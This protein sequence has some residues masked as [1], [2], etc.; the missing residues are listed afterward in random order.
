[1]LCYSCFA[2]EFIIDNFNNKG[3][4]KWIPAKWGNRKGASYSVKQDVMF[5]NFGTADKKT[6]KGFSFYA[7]LE[8][9]CDL[10]TYKYFCFKAR[11]GTD[12]ACSVRIY[13]KKEEPPGKNSSYYSIIRLTSEWKTYY[14]QLKTGKRSTVSKGLFI[15]VYSKIDVG[16]SRRLES[17]GKLKVLTFYSKDAQLVE[18]DD[19]VLKNDINRNSGEAEAI[20]E[21]IKKHKKYPP[22]KFRKVIG[23]NGS[24]LVENGKSSFVI[25]VDKNSGETGKFAA[26]QLAEYIKKSTGAELKIVE[27]CLPEQK[28][29]R[30]LIA[31]TVKHKEGFSTEALNPGTIVICGYD[32]RGLLYG[33]Y[34]FLEKALGIRWFAPFDYAEVI[35]TKTNVKLPLWKDESFPQ[36]TY[37][38]FHYCS[39]G[40]GVPDPMKH[41]YQVADWCV[42]NRYNVELERLVGKWDKPAVKKARMAKIKQFYVKRGG[43]IALPTMWG[44]NYHYW[45]SPKEYFKKHPEYFCFDSSTK[46]WR[47]ERAQLCATNP[48]LVKAIVKRAVEY[49]KEHPEREYFPLFQEDGS[50]LWC[51]CPKCRALYKGTDING[52]KTEHNINLMNL[53]AAKLAKVV[54]GK[55]VATYAYQVTSSPPVNVK[56]RDDIFVTYCL[57]GFSEPEKIPW[58]GYQGGE[59]A[60]WNKLCRGNLI[61]YTYHYLDFNYTAITPAALTRTFRYFNLMKIKGSCQES[62]ENWY[63]VSAY[64]YYLGA[65]LAWDPW[66][67]EKACRKDYYEKLYGKASSFIEE[68]H[69]VLK[70]CLSNRKYWLE[71]GN[72][73]FPYVPSDKLNTMQTCLNKAEIAAKGSARVNKAVEAQTRGFLYVKTFSEAVVAGAEF[74]KNPDTAKYQKAVKYLEQLN[75]VVKDLGRDRLVTI[76][77]LRTTRGMRRNLR[78]N[79]LRSNAFK[80]LV[81]EF[82][83]LKTLNPWKFKTD[84]Q[85]KGDR[86]KWFT[87]DFDDTKWKSIKSG[88]FWEKQG[89]PTYNGTGWYR[90]KLDIPKSK[91]ELGLYF[92][93]ADER[94]WVYFDGKYIGGHHTGDVTKLWNEPFSIMIPPGIA[95][96]THQLTVKVI[97]SGGGGGLWKNVFLVKKK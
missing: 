40:R 28:A 68:Y 43:Y 24:L 50:R 54:P 34:D 23:K 17:G 44:H 74:Q 58:S 5:L 13:I 60:A 27:N 95:P 67:D 92:G 9:P 20:A 51:Q 79:Y 18:I 64:N 36:M 48:D 6:D 39:M 88:N 61:L 73:T 70:T 30:L 97:D 84:P 12:K 49:F 52:Y 38:R 3:N 89:F 42:K 2:G 14:L 85:A 82:D 33:V 32:K 80:K 94:T 53:V 59:L 81:K 19:I 86:E 37:R 22:Y 71:Y 47:A 21:A 90:I 41:R 72:R 62:N 26:S 25:Q 46:K 10:K 66:F 75:K 45:I 96:G 29:V 31:P 87:V 57:T 65:K 7:K 63:G 1:M 93:G 4:C 11:S 35:P 78:E 83:I 76:I 15:P 16:A 8:Q 77:V 55:Q 91:S 69:N 56:P